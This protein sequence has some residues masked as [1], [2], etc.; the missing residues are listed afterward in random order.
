MRAAAVRARTATDSL[1]TA[2]SATRAAALRVRTAADTLGTTDSAAGVASGG[3]AQS[4]TASDSLSTTDTA[5]RGA[6]TRV[7]TA[8]DA[9]TVSDSATRGLVS[10]RTGGGGTSSEVTAVA[11]T[12]PVPHSGDA[13]DD[14]AIWLHPTDPAKSTIIGTDKLGGL[15][16]H[17]LQGQ[18][19]QYYAD[20]Q[21]NNVDLRYNFPLGGER[22]GLVAT[23]D[24]TTDSIRLYKVD[25]QTRELV[26]V[27][28]RQIS[29]GHG[30]YGLCMYHS[31]QSGKYYV[32]ESDNSGTV[33]QWELF[34]AGS[35]KVDARKVRSFA[36]G[37]TT[38]GCV[39]DDELGGVYISEE[40]VQ[41]TLGLVD[42]DDRRSPPR[43]ALGRSVPS[44]CPA[45]RRDGSRTSSPRA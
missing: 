44:S 43:T 34:D 9:T 38:E 37:S 1:G 41:D 22:V 7:R 11:E 18:Q 6:V 5:T 2:D 40:D 35:G 3:G 10:N 42:K 17:D 36:V 12:Q 8:T 19:L 15:A 39:A 24:R 28:A 26:S 16:V 30:L 27:S 20:S 23:S 33:Q 4:R 14:P 32:F 45:D 31:P 29:T 21:P 13:A 25:A